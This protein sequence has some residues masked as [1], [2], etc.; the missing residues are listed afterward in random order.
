MKRKRIAA[1]LLSLL[2]LFSACGQDGGQTPEPEE[3]TPVSLTV[4]TGGS[5]DTLDP[6]RSTAPGGETVLY[7]LFENLMRWSDGGQGWAAVSPGQAERYTV[8][9]DYAGNA[10]YTFT[11]RQ[12]AVW[13]DGRPVTAADFVTAWRRLADPANESPHREL[14][15]CVSGYDQ[16]QETGDAGLL[17]VSAPDERTFVVSLNGSCSYFLEEICTGAYTMPVREDL[18]AKSGWGASAADTVTNGAYTIAEWDGGLVRLERSETYYNAA[19]IGPEEL[20]FVSAASPAA[21][22][23]RFTDGEFDLTTSLPDSALRELAD[24]GTWTPEPVTAGYGVLLNTAAPPFDD[25][26]VR[27]AFRLAIDAQAV[28]DAL[29]DPAVRPAVGLIPYGVGDYGQRPAVEETEEEPALCWDFRTHSL[30]KVTV[31]TISNYEDDCRQAKQLMAQA[32]YANGNGF[33]A[34]EYLYVKSGGNDAVAQ[35]LRQMWQEKLGVAV[36]LRGVSQKAYDAAVA[37]APDTDGADAEDTAEPSGGGEEKNS[38]FTMAAQSFP[39]PYSDAAALLEFWRGG[40]PDNPTG[41]QSDALD[42]LLETARTAAVPDVRDALL[43]D[44]EAVLLTEAPVIPICYQGGAYLFS[45]KWSGL[46]RAPDGVYFLFNI[47]PAS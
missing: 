35:A 25:P 45:G 47:Q 11:L 43:H 31:P 7:H 23:Q 26:D 4:C 20:R 41:Y 33:P 10:S 17:A 1:L 15:A 22:Y 27:L 40:N 2:L 3:E 44:A 21:D 13:S 28:V 16:V 38:S 36:V 12:D 34:V 19:A 18:A 32:G 8:E 5:Q 24:A 30:E 46:Y 39:A 42:L 9:T 37:P 29:G 6:A 14:M